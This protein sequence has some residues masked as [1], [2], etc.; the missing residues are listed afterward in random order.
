MELILKILEAMGITTTQVLAVGFSAVMGVISV[1]IVNWLKG[2]L[3]Q[4]ASFPIVGALIPAET[5]DKIQGW[6]TV[7][8]SGVVGLVFVYIGD[9]VFG[10]HVFE[11]QTVYTALITAFG[12]NQTFGA[13]FF[14]WRK[15]KTA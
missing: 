1:P 4:V 8:V 10:L 14:E 5:Y 6:F 3:A 9:G 12:I 7:V 13:I 11:N 15:S 2:V